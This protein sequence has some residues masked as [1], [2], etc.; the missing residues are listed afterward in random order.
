MSI[1]TDL[2]EVLDLTT[3]QHA[4]KARIDIL[5]SRLDAAARAEWER[6]GAAPSWKTKGMGVVR[7]DGADADLTAT[8]TDGHAYASYMA[9]HHP[10]ETVATLTLDPTQLEAALQALEFAEVT[11]HMAD[12]T[13]RPGFAKVHLAGLT[14]ITH[15]DEDGKDVHEFLEVDGE[16]DGS[17]E[18]WNVPGLTAMQPP[19]RFVIA[20]DAKAKSDAVHEAVLEQEQIDAEQ[21]A[22]EALLA[23]PIEPETEPDHQVDAAPDDADKVA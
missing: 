2:R 11:V 15:K 22:I 17:G 3:R 14:L 8:V 21:A 6:T 16:D 10:S 18:A 13:A 5:R 12:V 9:E 4:T 1:K 7:L 20:V 23:K 19:P